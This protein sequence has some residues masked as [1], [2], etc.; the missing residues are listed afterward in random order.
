MHRLEQC[1][2]MRAF[3]LKINSVTTLI[4]IEDIF[5]IA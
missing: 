2:L 4:V 3:L 5:S 1:P